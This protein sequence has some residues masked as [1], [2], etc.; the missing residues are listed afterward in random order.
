MN[1][2]TAEIE[3]MCKVVNPLCG[4]LPPD[5]MRDFSRLLQGNL[6]RVPKVRS[7]GRNPQFDHEESVIGFGNGFDWLHDVN[8]ALLLNPFDI[9]S[10]GPLKI[11]G[12]VISGN[13][14]NGRITKENGLT[15]MVSSPFKEMGPDYK[16]AILKADDLA[17]LAYKVLKESNPELFEAGMQFVVGVMDENTR[18]FERLP[19]E[20]LRNFKKLGC[21]EGSDNPTTK[22][23]IARNA[24]QSKF[25]IDKKFERLVYRNHYPTEVM[26]FKCMD[27]RIN[28]PVATETP[29]GILQPVRN[30]GAKFSMGWKPLYDKVKG[31][32][33]YSISK[34]R[35]CLVLAT[36]HFSKTDTHLGCAGH[37]YDTDA[38]IRNAEELKKEID[39]VF[40]FGPSSP[41][42]T[43]VVGFNTDDDS[44]IVH[45]MDGKSKFDI[46]EL[47]ENTTPQ[48]SPN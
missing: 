35:N 13:L 15:L 40:G 32:L 41:I 29:V 36:Y 45:S 24:E 2:K 22:Y 47:V 3:K 18:L 5:V 48:Q 26:I 23:L 20:K 42:N 33:E 16:H 19:Y 7:S 4:E 25:F 21:V 34:N 37:G 43:I 30:V 6:E 1:V 12:K 46:S 44:L 8:R 11:A 9:D 28:L 38:A 39:E 17:C 10:I 27:G 31:W 14:Q